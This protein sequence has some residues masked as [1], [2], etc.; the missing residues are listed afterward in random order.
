[1]TIRLPEDLHGKLRGDAKRAN[2]SMS[3]LIRRRLEE[4]DPLLEVAGIFSDGTLCDLDEDL[5]EI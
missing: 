3:D 1:L 5:Y 2:V 4:P